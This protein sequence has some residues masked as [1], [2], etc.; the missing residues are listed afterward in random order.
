MAILGI[1]LNDYAI[2]GVS[3][4][5]VLF[6]EPGAALLRPQGPLFGVAARAEARNH[7][8]AYIDRYWRDLSEKPLPRGVGGMESYA[9]LAYAQCAN[10]WSQYGSEISAVLC[11]VPPYWDKKQLALL[12]GIVQEV[13]M[14]LVGLT[15]IPVA[16]TRRRYPDYD[17]THI[18]FA[19]GAVSLT[20]MIQGERGSSQGTSDMIP[21]LGITA[22]ERTSAEY[23]A[24]K[25]L[26]SSRFDPM[27]DAQSE[28]SVY[29]NLPDWIE[30]LA[31][32]PETELQFE[33]KGNLF[34][35][36]VGLAELE[37]RLR[38]R[39]QPLI[40]ALRARFDANRPVALQVNSAVRSFPGVVESLADL[41]GCDVF[42]LEQAAA[43]RGLVSRN[44]SIKKSTGALSVTEAL[45]WDQPEADVSLQRA[46]ASSS[47]GVPSHV[48]IGSRAY[49]LSDEPLRIGAELSEAGY[50]IV[51][52]ARHSGVS[53]QHC[54]IEL[55]DGKAVL[56]DY[57]RFG[58][59]LNGHKVER[60][61]VLQP[62]DVV[63]IGNPACE[64]QLIVE[65]GASDSA[66]RPGH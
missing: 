63:S 17:L 48:L 2:T 23:F 13:G 30:S 52:P 51:I 4:D 62:G 3:D 12:L 18:E 46:M 16:A 9:D 10:I 45:P 34:S 31:R 25:F 59:R 11:A 24:R 64:L 6:V 38:Y 20:E 33:Y 41:P 29:R 58:T 26:E 32:M 22:L 53:R 28:Q 39:C 15:T 49:R 14:P 42:V 65:T 50:S 5:R 7:P 36:R 40:Q 8:S 21:D 37:D 43:A 61:T 57:S 60:S 54:S 55:R 19:A 44:A 56:N 66:A 1:E 47:G 35:A 27:H